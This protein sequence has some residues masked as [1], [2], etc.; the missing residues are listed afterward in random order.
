MSETL[1]IRHSTR[2]HLNGVLHRS[3]PS[4][5]VCISIPLIVARQRPGRHVPA[6]KK[7]CWRRRFLCGPCRT[8]EESVSLSV[9]HPMVAKQRLG[10]HVPTVTNNFGASFSI[11]SVSYQ[12]RINVSVYPLMVAKQRLG[13]HVLAAKKNC[14]RRRSLYGPCRTKEEFMG[15]S[16][17][18]LMVAKQRFG[19]HVPPA[20][21]NYW[22]VILYC[23]RSVSYERKAGD[24]FCCKV[25]SRM[26]GG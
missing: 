21:N 3:L 4:I 10:K 13:K 19:K 7:N 11:R 6:A 20:T 1:Y 15:L 5:C 8:E 12:R 16:V 2:A 22:S 17:Y 9:Y 26:S 24:Q 25:N 23:M 18:P 14:W